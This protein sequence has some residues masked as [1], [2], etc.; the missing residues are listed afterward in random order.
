MRF[1]E[2]N[3]NMENIKESP[4]YYN[5]NKFKCIKKGLLNYFPKDI[6]I[7]TQCKYWWECY[8]LL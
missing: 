2:R 5:G 8:N 3:T 4:I 6:N 7:L 1:K